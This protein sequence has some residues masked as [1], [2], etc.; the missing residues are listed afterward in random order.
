MLW[1][2]C[3]SG[4]TEYNKIRFAIFGFYCDFIRFSKSQLKHAKENLFYEWTPG[5]IR[6]FT[7]MPSLCAQT[8]E[9]KTC[10]AIRS[11]CLRGDAARRTPARPA[12]RP[13]GGAGENDQ[14]LTTDPMVAEIG[15]GTTPVMGLGGGRRWAPLELGRRRGGSAAGATSKRASFRVV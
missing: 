1:E 12:A 9:K 4:Y 2:S 7:T 13:A 14:E 5:N 3:S 15:V 8:P 6:R 10:E 11:L